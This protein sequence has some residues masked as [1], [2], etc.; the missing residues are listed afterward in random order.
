M[1][2]FVLVSLTAILAL[3]G[4]QFQ[5]GAQESSPGRREPVARL[6]L[7]ALATPVDGAAAESA[8]S[9]VD[10]APGESRGVSF[11]TTSDLCAV[12]IGSSTAPLRSARHV[13][14]FEFA[15]I[16]ASTDRV[17]VDVSMD[18]VDERSAASARHWR[19]RLT[20][21][22]GTPH[23]L[24]FVERDDAPSPGCRTANLVLEVSAD[25]VETATLAGQVLDYDL[26][27]IDHVPG[28]PDSTS[29]QTL[30]GI[31]GQQLPF[32]F[33]VR[34]SLAA[35]LP[36]Q[37]LVGDLVETVSGAIR[38]R[39][40]ENGQ[41]DIALNTSRVLAV[42]DGSTGDGGLKLFNVQEGERVSLELPAPHGR[43]S[44]PNASGGRIFVT[45]DELLQHHV[46][47]VILSVNRRRR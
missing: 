41:I 46:T 24:D 4:G 15:L 32:R 14:R 1:K 33:E 36:S 35:L 11:A 18:R 43:R 13:W 7:K 25:L 3:A 9:G 28:R 34:W 40:H 31:Q 20:V 2:A 26:W 23:V 45:D 10:L 30:S 5:T 47:S 44:A 29:R 12:M 17:V 6:R 42:G 38:G 16:S 37:Q 21:A 8:E 39:A 22:E 27:L 19:R